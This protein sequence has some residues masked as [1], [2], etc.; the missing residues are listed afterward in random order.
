MLIYKATCTETG[1]SYIGATAKTL[2]RRI[3]LH[4]AR[5]RFGSHYH[6]HNALRKYGVAAFTWEVLVDG[7]ESRDE[8]DRQEIRLIEEN[9]TVECGYNTS[10]GG[11]GGDNW[12]N[13]PR[14]EEIRQRLRDANLGKKMSPRTREIMSVSQVKRWEGSDSPLKGKPSLFAGQR[15]TAEAKNRMS[16]AKKDK[17]LHKRHRERIGE[18]L[19]GKMFTEEHK[20]KIA[21]SCRGQKRS[22]ETCR[23]ISESKKGKRLG[24][25]L[26]EDKVRLIRE[27][28]GNR[29]EGVSLQQQ[30]DIL[31]EE[32]GVSSSAIRKIHYRMTWD[33]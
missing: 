32:F 21:A 5:A 15:H 27:K 12:A 14:Q 23:R 30:W 28:I 22:P 17:P 10:T 16:Q 29:D 11:G 25:K 19:R 7:I 3:E 1:K 33:V 6:F 31:A 20:Q 8:L 9:Q 13:N 4:L 2:K 26:T 18:A 24:G